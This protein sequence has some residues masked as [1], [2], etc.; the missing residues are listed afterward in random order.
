MNTR[1]YNQAQNTPFGTGY[2]AD[3]I[4]FNIEKPAAMA[5]DTLMQNSKITRDETF[6]FPVRTKTPEVITVETAF[7]ASATS[8]IWL[9]DYYFPLGPLLRVFFPIPIALA[10]LRWGAR[11]AWMTA[12]YQL[13]SCRTEA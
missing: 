3:C 9:I 5:T 12:A 1:Q 6:L 8:L 10:Y 11:C 2:L 4:G 7:L 13:S